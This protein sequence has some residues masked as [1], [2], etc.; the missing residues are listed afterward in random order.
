[1]RGSCG[2]TS[3]HLPSHAALRQILGKHVTQAGS[4]V[5]PDHLRFDFTHGKPMTPEELAQV[6]FIVNQEAE[7]HPGDNLRRSADRRGQSKGR[8]GSLRRKIWL[9]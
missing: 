7:E 3:P 1:M 5:G 8:D 2:I 6:E 4:Y 9:P